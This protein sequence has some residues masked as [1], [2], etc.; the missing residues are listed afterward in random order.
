LDRLPFG[1][2]L[3]ERI[4]HGLGRIVRIVDEDGERRV[5]AGL[6]REWDNAVGVGGPFDQHD[7]RID[8]IER[9]DDARGRARPV[10]ADAEKMEARAAHITSRIAS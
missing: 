5:H 1:R 8:R 10:M 3:G 2:K 7:R 4:E 9:R 6:R